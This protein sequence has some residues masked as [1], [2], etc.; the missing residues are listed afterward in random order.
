LQ[1]AG[2]FFIIITLF[3]DKDKTMSLTYPVHPYKG[4]VKANVSL[5]GSKS[6][7]NR[8]LMLSALA[9][10]TTKLSNFLFSDDTAFMSKAL[11]SAGIQV[12][13]DEKKQE[14][15]VRGG[16]L[17][18]GEL[19]LFLGN[20][21]TAMRF[22]SSYFT[23]GNG[24]FM[25][26]GDARM[27]QRPIKDLLDALSQLGCDIRSENSD[28]CPPVRINSSGMPG[29]NCRIIGKNS[30]QYISSLLMAS[31][32]S[33]DGVN[34]VTDGEVA[35]GPYVDMTLAMMRQYGL[36]SERTGYSK[37]GILPGKYKSP[38]EYKIEPDAS[39]A[40]YFLA[41]AAVLGGE[42][43]INGI[44]SG[45]IQGDIRF[46]SVLEKMGCE[47]VIS[48]ES[49][50]LRSNGKLKGI[51]EDMNDIPDMAATLAVCALFADGPTKIIKVPNLR[52]KESD[53]ISALSAELKKLGSGIKENEDGLEIFP[54]SSYNSAII[55]TYN[56]HRIAMSF[57]IA[58]LKI[59][60]L[61]IDNPSCVSKTFP[62]FYRYF[63]TV[64]DNPVEF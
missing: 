18:G 63:G 8:A 21:G 37:F 25:L 57:S 3:I 59:G 41:G 34:I 4:V 19:S 51:T 47:V 11:R 13:M 56:D 35:S 27:R 5:P 61:E 31:P 32:Y 62:D 39:N 20:A 49:I 46:A 26:D 36:G 29:G 16:V 45:S 33:R 48:G 58:G 52:I 14:C 43:V 28:G 9:E 64:F 55:N 6:I 22:L 1:I 53:R 54:G 12:I 40:S 42:I 10:G 30:S 44:G 7:T 38:K 60:G 17:P 24:V 23:L 15:T 2:L 50:R